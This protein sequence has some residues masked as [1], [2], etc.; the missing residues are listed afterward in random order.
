MYENSPIESK[1][2]RPFIVSSSLYD[3]AKLLQF[4][5]WLI[6]ETETPL[7]ITGL[8]D[9]IFGRPDGSIAKL[10]ILEGKYSFL[11][12]SSDEYNRQKTS[13]EWLEKEFLINWYEIAIGNQLI[14]T[15]DQC[16]GWKL[17]PILGGEITLDNLQLYFMTVYQW[18]QGQIHQKI[19][20]KI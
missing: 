19:Q 16:I 3:S 10:D 9:W 1:K 12:K 4:W 8:G 11:S 15:T 14:P 2:T 6:P 13:R 5:R 20:H 17:A 7:F 18:S